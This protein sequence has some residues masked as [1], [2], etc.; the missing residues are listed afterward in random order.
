MI[1]KQQNKKAMVGQM[2]VIA[3]G[4]I[5]LI[6]LVG[7]GSTVLTKLG[8]TQASCASTCGAAGTYNESTNVCSNASAANCGA[9]GGTVYTAINYGNTQIGSTG[10]LSWLPALIALLVGVFFLSYFAGKKDSGKEY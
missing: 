5:A 2:Q 6:I 7:I 10:M 1:T 9:A 4:I 8:A 3:F